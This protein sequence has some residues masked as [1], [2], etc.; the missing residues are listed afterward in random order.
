MKNEIKIIEDLIEEQKVVIIN[1]E[2]SLR[3]LKRLP[4]EFALEKKWDNNKMKV[5][6][7]TPE[8]RIPSV[9]KNLQLD[10]MMLEELESIL[11]E[12]KNDQRHNKKL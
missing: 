10:K 8:Q 9:E 7:I 1:R 2:A 5:I 6:D 11:E 3:T 12:K 4:L